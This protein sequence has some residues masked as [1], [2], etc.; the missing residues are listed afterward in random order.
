MLCAYFL[1]HS[2]LYIHQISTR[3]AEKRYTFEEKEIILVPR[4]DLILG[5]PLSGD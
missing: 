4:R 2:H 3:Y 1:D 5:Y